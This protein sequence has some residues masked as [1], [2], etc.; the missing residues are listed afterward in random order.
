MTDSADADVTFVCEAFGLGELR[1]ARRVARGA[2]GAVWRIDADPPGSSSTATYAAKELFWEVPS[3][4]AAEDEVRFTGRCR[5]AG[6]PSPRSLA[7]TAGGYVAHDPLGQAWRVYE[8]VDGEVPDRTDTETVQWLAG[9]LGRIHALGLEPGDDAKPDPFY[10]RV[11]VDWDEL[12]DD[13][14][15]AGVD[16]WP[17]LE[18]ATPQL[19]ELSCLVNASPDGRPIMCHR[20]PK[21]S[22][23][24]RDAAGRRWLVD[25][26]NAGPMA[27]W[28]ELGLL[29]MHHLADVDALRVIGACYRDH[30]GPAQL[31]TAQGFAT[32]L[33]T[34]LNFLRGQAGVLLDPKATPDH[35]QFA[36]QRVTGLLRNIPALEQLDHA[37]SAAAP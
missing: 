7:A 16:W 5:Q 10:Q 26:D 3:A 29:L 32:G 35:R 9:Q 1:G 25:W 18:A 15:R 13:A 27:P 21:A 33:A 4:S 19:V 24:L 2:M 20:D 30:G 11:D 8:W 14:S 36:E 22:N 37:A 23:V 31:G 28:R 6:V 34:W 12:A 17:A